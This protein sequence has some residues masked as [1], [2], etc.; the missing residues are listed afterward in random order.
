MMTKNFVFVLLLAAQESSFVHD[1]QIL[2]HSIFPWLTLEDAQVFAR[3]NRRHHRE[4]LNHRKKVVMSLYRQAIS[5]MDLEIEEFMEIFPVNPSDSP[6][7]SNTFRRIIKGKGRLIIKLVC[8]R[9]CEECPFLQ[10]D[11]K[12]GEV[13]SCLMLLGLGKAIFVEGYP[14]KCVDIL[15]AANTGK[16]I[17]VPGCFGKFMLTKRHGEYH[18]SFE[19]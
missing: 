18:Y 10:F 15:R 13:E 9:Q 5:T 19:I 2:R 1:E 3:T 6:M 8:D 17:I 14:A 16:E 4:M 11:L 12:N 7:E